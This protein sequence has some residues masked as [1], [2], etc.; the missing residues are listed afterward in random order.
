MSQKFIISFFIICFAIFLKVGKGFT[1]E[2]Q[3]QN[4]PQKNYVL[5][6]DEIELSYSLGK[7]ICIEAEL[8]RDK[9]PILKLGKT[10]IYCFDP[11]VIDLR[12]G[13]AKDII[14]HEDLKLGESVKVKV[15]GKLGQRID[16]YN[17]DFPPCQ[18]LSDIE[19]FHNTSVKLTGT[20]KYVNAGKCWVAELLLLDGSKVVVGYSPD[21]E[22][23][24]F[25]ND[26]TV[27]IYG[28]ISKSHPESN[29]SYQWLMFPHIT[30]IILMTSEDK[31]FVSTS[32][33]M[34][35]YGFIIYYDKIEVVK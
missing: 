9:L 23:A 24:N 30:N 17:K 15:W 4:P 1:E 32:D 20:Y 13:A 11:K 7:N 27:I 18:S 22:E 3:I 5:L 29:E 33:Q 31:E 21:K 35:P 26:K 28:V 16:D 12:H 34:D 10:W 14:I 25:L 2:I 19:K 8:Y 6:N